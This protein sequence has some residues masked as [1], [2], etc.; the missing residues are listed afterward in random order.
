MFLD[1]T[2]FLPAKEE[3]IFVSNMKEY[4]RE[5]K[6]NPMTS[7]ERFA[8]EEGREEGMKKG[9]LEAAKIIMEAKFGSISTAL[10]TILEQ[11]DTIKLKKIIRELAT[12]SRPED[13]DL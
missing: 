4:E 11:A 10:L 9:E 3:K 12:T 13:I 8:R 5:A 1:Y 6:V 7:F 2:L